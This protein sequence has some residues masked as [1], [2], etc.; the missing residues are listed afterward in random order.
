VCTDV[1]PDLDTKSW[2]GLCGRDECGEVRRGT[3]LCCRVVGHGRKGGH[4]ID[5]H[6]GHR[7]D[8]RRCRFEAVEGD[9]AFHAGQ[10]DVMDRIRHPEQQALLDSCV[11][12]SY[13]HLG[14][15]LR[16]EDG[17]HLRTHRDDARQIRHGSLHEIAD[18]AES[19]AVAGQGVRT[20]DVHR[21]GFRILPGG[22]RRYHQRVA[23]D[24]LG[25]EVHPQTQGVGAHSDCRRIAL[26]RLQIQHEG[27]GRQASL[28][29]QRGCRREKF[30]V[31]SLQQ[32]EEHGDLSS[33]LALRW[34]KYFL[35]KVS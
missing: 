11:V 32:F 24:L 20:G 30:G 12:G 19:Y 18:M 35:R 3:R 13:G 25:H 6:P 2:E 23:A 4:T 10:V 21:H 27:V 31:A 14:G 34:Y 9:A 17:H 15:L 26:D 8:L 33:V 16:A 7:L 22:H 28:N 5:P 1:F 29:S